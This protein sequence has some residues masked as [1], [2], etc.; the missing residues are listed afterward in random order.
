MDLKGKVAIIN[1]LSSA[2]GTVIGKTLLENGVHI[3]GTYYSRKENTDDLIQKFG[4]ERVKLFKI[5]FLEDDYEKGIKEIVVETKKCFGKI[6]ILINVSGVWVV[7]PFLYEEKKE[8]EQVWRI[9]YWS[10][11][12]FAKKIIPYMMND[13]GSIINIASTAGI[14]GAGQETSY[15][16]SKAAI[17]NLARSLAEEFAPR[18]I[19]VNA[20]SPGYT[21]TLALD[22]Y[23]DDANKELLIK[24][25]PMAR[26]C[27]PEDIANT[28][29]Y[30]LQNDYVTGVNIPLHGG[31]L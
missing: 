18:H 3:S 2:I 19:R 26:F 24:H 17:I 14:D 6:D 8:I 23:F 31:R 29:L 15:S 1:G 28:V 5:D 27:K 22:K 25:I 10:T 9:N 12:E 7:K 13:G 16:A 21:D 30:L 4:N 20:I 11:Y